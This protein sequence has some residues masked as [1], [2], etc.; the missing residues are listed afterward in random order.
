MVWTLVE[1]IK[2]IPFGG[3]FRPYFT[4]Q[5][6]D[7]KRLTN[8]TMP[9]PQGTVL[10]VT[11]RMFQN[12]LEFWPHTIRVARP[13]PVTP[14]KPFGG[15]SLSNM[16][17]RGTGSTNKRRLDASIESMTVKHRPFLS[18]DK[19]LLKELIDAT[20]N[21]QSTEA[22]DNIILPILPVTAKRPIPEL[23]R[24][25]LKSPNFATWL[26]HRT[27]EVGR[28]WQH[29]YF[30]V[31]CFS[32]IASWAKERLNAHADVECIDLLLRLR[33][34]VKKYAPFF[35]VEDDRVNYAHLARAS[36]N[37]V[38]SAAVA[39]SAPMPSDNKDTRRPNSTGVVLSHAASSGPLLNRPEQHERPVK[40]YDPNFGIDITSLHV[41]ASASSYH[42]D[43]R[44]MRAG[45]TAG[46]SAS[47]ISRPR[48]PPPHQTYGHGPLSN[49][50]TTVKT[51]GV[52]AHSS[53][54]RS[55]TFKW[56]SRY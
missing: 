29:Q 22:L 42:T 48:T 17:N 28:E 37:S 41:S 55:D 12:A 33:N 1:L 50:Q 43:R 14:I 25:F 36:S 23:Y 3:D 7:F 20:S 35:V 39:L 13:Q 9:P 5:D 47:D 19:R 30:N 15:A 18:K 10:G 21:G 52:P 6:A 44:G 54:E 27:A 40:N 34:E 53:P 38:A 16:N 24:Q 26:Q 46:K 31:L 2:P 49:S 56:P 45:A 11:N 4:I 8:R 51:S 32:D